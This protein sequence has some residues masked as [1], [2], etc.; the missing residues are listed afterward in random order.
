[1][2]HVRG[3]GGV[4][5]GDLV[6]TLSRCVCVENRRIWLSFWLQVNKMSENMS[7]KMGVEFV[8]P[9]YLGSVFFKYIV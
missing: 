4:E 3:G 5:G 2:I 7:F 6:S 9:L 1:M 8:V